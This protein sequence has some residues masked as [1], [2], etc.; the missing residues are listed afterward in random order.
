MACVCLCVFRSIYDI[1]LI[2]IY[3]YV[4]APYV[5]DLYILCFPVTGGMMDLSTTS[6]GYPQPTVSPNDIGGQKGSPPTGSSVGGRPN[7]RVVIPT[8]RGEVVSE[9]AVT[10]EV[11]SNFMSTAS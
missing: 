5:T 4:P 9:T 1:T 2:A 7:L 3:R 10:E 8:A 6:N 11:S